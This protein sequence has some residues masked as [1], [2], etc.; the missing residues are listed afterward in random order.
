[1]RVS[2]FVK[3]II[4]LIIVGLNINI[5]QEKLNFFLQTYW[6]NHLPQIH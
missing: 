4:L 3:S 2:L 1:M 5:A 6:S